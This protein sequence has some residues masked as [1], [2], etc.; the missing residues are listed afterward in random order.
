MRFFNNKEITSVIILPNK[1][2][3]T[4]PGN[5]SEKVNFLDLNK[6][7][8]KYIFGNFPVSFDSEDEKTRFLKKRI[9]FKEYKPTQKSVEKVSVTPVYDAISTINSGEDDTKVERFIENPVQKNKKH[10][11]LTE[12]NKEKETILKDKDKEFL[13]RQHV[14]SGLDDTYVI[15]VDVDKDYKKPEEKKDYNPLGDLGS[16]ELTQYL[17]GKKN[18]KKNKFRR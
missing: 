8:V 7:K 17:G 15:D 2:L 12:E 18:R 5:V 14:L 16:E 4:K 1:K 13:D 3:V 6:A 10:Q 11:Y 9:P